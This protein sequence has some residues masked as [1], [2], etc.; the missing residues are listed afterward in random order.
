MSRS[1]HVT[2]KSVF[3]GKPKSEIMKMISENDPDV[4]AL[5]AK[6]MAKIQAIAKRVKKRH[7]ED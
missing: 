6:K 2:I 3:G 1:K 4:E 7:F 5:R